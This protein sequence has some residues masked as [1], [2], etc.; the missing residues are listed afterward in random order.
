[1]PQ[2]WKTTHDKLQQFQALGGHVVALD[3][4]RAARWYALAL[5]SYAVREGD[6]TRVDAAHR[7]RP[8]TADEFADFIQH[9]CY[10][11]SAS[12]FRDVEA[13]FAGPDGETPP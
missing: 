1:L 2:T 12:A 4:E 10:G 6:V 8:I 11:A 9:A 13:V 3:Q 5:L 7:M